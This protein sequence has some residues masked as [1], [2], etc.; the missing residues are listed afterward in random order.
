MRNW[1]VTQNIL[2]LEWFVII[3]VFITLWK[4]GLFIIILFFDYNI[5]Q[6]I[7]CRPAFIVIFAFFVVISWYFLHMMK[8]KISY[9]TCRL[10]EHKSKTQRNSTK[11]ELISFWWL[12]TSNMICA[13]ACLWYCNETIA[14]HIPYDTKIINNIKSH[15]Y[16]IFSFIMLDS[17]WSWFIFFTMLKVQYDYFCF[18]WLHV[19]LFGSSSNSFMYDGAQP[20]H[21]DYNHK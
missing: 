10:T 16:D 15:C 1:R 17:S 7:F 2:M 6:C 5:C 3:M 4:R 9:E 12:K 8:L 21:T 19:M 18:L 11:T 13:C 14:Y 20:K